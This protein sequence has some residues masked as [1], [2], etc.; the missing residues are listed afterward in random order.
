MEIFR[1]AVI[2]MAFALPLG[3]VP[4][5]AQVYHWDATAYGGY[6]WVTGKVL[7][8]A[9]FDFVFDNE[10]VDREDHVNLGNGGIFGAQL[11]Y[12]FNTRFGLRGNFSYTNS[13]ISARRFVF[14]GDPFSLFDH[15]VNLYG[16]TGDL[17]VRLNKPNTR[18]DGFE[19]LP[20]IALG[21]GANW[22]SPGGTDFRIIDDD[23]DT[24]IDDDID[25]V[26]G[27]DAV[28]IRCSAILDRC[29]VL[30]Q[31]T[32]LT[33]LAA[34]GMD[35]R[36]TPSFGLRLEFGDRIWEAPVK[37]V[38]T[39]LDFPFFFVESRDLGNTVNQL[40]LT[41]GATFMF[42]FEHP[43]VRA[44]AVPPRPA[45]PPPP[46]PPPPATEQITVCV[47]DPTSAEGVRSITATRHLTTGDTTVTKDG[48]QMSLSSAL[49]NVPVAGNAN[50]Y[51]RGAPLQ[52]G[53][54]PKPL[55][56]TP[57]GGERHIEPNQ[58][59]YLGTVDGMPVF[60][61]RSTSAV[62]LTQLGPNT[63]LNRLLTESADARKA[64]ESVSILYVPTQ[65]S[66]CAFTAVQKVQEVRKNDLQ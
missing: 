28:P 16:L 23:F 8:R 44:A 6:S 51:I 61:D 33:G 64:M 50:W 40:Y 49:G 48:Q 32:K 11:G 53:M 2:T 59:A 65:P 26:D 7:D 57:V 62:G 31:A 38:F 41:L 27:I 10:L 24:I 3:A 63:D 13:D 60:V 21:I 45:P 37:E 43:P 22:V 1:K 29:A 36:F 25:N 54:G 55:Q 39:D 47:I 12:W 58:L 9:D 30:E 15:N 14:N 20:Y 5:A 18:W 35:F 56:F 19:W 42:G 52:I 17:M 46:P 66:G 4:L 34:V